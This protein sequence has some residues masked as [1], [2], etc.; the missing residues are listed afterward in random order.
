ML[1]ALPCA[2]ADLFL[3]P[4]SFAVSQGERVSVTIAGSTWKPAEVIEPVLIASSGIYNLTNLRESEGA[5]VVDGTAK[6]KGSLIAAARGIQQRDQFFAKALL[7]CDAESE[8]ARKPVGHMFEIVPQGPVAGG[9]LPVQILLRGG[10]AARIALELESGGRR[11][12]VGITGDSGRFEVAVGA[13]V[14]R[15][16]AEYVEPLGT[17]RASLSFEVK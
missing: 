1:F 4:S 15:I 12:R 2:A 13:G 7:V 5:L 6:A 9:K 16:I 10:G 3:T 17:L 8:L 11:Q 14:S